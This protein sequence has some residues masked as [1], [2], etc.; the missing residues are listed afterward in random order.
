[1]HV[2]PS[3]ILMFC[4]FVCWNVNRVREIYIAKN[5]FYMPAYLANKIWKMYHSDYEYVNNVLLWCSFSYGFLSMF[6][7]LFSYFFIHRIH[8]HW[9]G[10]ELNWCFRLLLPLHHIIISSNKCMHKLVLHAIFHI[11]IENTVL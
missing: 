7:W 2:K 3:I 4:V 5:I 1:M 10:I 8:S 11:C 6:V 9:I